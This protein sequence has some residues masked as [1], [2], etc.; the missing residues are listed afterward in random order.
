MFLKT[1]HKRVDPCI[2]NDICAFPSHLGRIAG[3]EILHMNRGRDHGAGNTQTFADMA[4]HL[5]AK[6]HLG[7]G[8]FD[9]LLN[10]EIIVTDQGL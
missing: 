8:F 5:R 1:H 2:E 10:G 3:R 4:L 6:D 9:G 7:R